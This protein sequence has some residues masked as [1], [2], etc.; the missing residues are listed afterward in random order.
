M[1]YPLPPIERSEYQQRLRRAQLLM[2]AQGL[3]ALLV[4]IEMNFRYFSGLHS[5]AWVMPTRPMFLVLP[6][7][8][9]PVAIIPTGSLVGMRQQS[10]IADLRTW[11]APTL[12]DDG[13]SLLR[14]ALS[15][16]TGTHDRIGT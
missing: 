12:E 11:P 6:A 1:Q 15:E 14:D 4:T 7:D 16:I 13:V 8:R 5:Q 3:A 9:D 10:W 2:A